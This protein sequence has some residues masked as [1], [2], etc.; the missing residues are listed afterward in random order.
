MWDLK[1]ELCPGLAL[2]PP[3]SHTSVSPYHILL[4]QASFPCQGPRPWWS[5]SPLLVTGTAP[6]IIAA[7]GVQSSGSAW[8]CLTPWGRAQN[9]AQL[10]PLPLGQAA[11]QLPPGPR[12]SLLLLSLFVNARKDKDSWYLT[13]LQSNFCLVTIFS[14]SRISLE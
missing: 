13:C 5:F 11:L 9:Q 2:S 14:I 4:Q 6:W 1:Q 8:D 7:L 3:L 12:L 10:L